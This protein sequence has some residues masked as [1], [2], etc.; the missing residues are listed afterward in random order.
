MH[1][2]IKI[3]SPFSNEAITENAAQIPVHAHVLA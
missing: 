2:Y 3:R 1:N